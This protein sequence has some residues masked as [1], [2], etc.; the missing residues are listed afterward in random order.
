MEILAEKSCSGAAEKEIEILGGSRVGS[1]FFVQG[2]IIFI[3]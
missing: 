2:Q 1:S 3:Q